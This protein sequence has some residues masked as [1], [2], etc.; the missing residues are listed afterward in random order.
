[1]T[2]GIIYPDIVLVLFFYL[3]NLNPVSIL[4]NRRRKPPIIMK[5]YVFP[6]YRRFTVPSDENGFQIR[7]LYR[8]IHILKRKKS[9]FYMQL[10]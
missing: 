7:I 10:E 4:V 8:K 2:F 6:D 9:Y 3:Q 1:M 5:F